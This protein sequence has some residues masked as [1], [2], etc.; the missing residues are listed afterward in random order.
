M[1]FLKDLDDPF[2]MYDISDVIDKDNQWR[3]LLPSV[4]TFYGEK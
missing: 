1:F 3:K 4:E 2:F